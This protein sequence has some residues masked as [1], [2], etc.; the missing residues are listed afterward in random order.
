MQHQTTQ[1]RLACTEFHAEAKL[2]LVPD[3]P[4]I[5]LAQ[6]CLHY[7]IDCIGCNIKLGV[8]NIQSLPTETFSRTPIYWGAI[9]CVHIQV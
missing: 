8:S 6:A 7:Y 1:G 5:K 3:L 2:L 9:K 4:S